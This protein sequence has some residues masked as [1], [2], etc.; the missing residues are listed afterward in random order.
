MDINYSTTPDC[1]GPQQH[2]DRGAPGPELEDG[3]QPRLQHLQQATG[4]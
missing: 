1:R 4:G 3:A 2:R